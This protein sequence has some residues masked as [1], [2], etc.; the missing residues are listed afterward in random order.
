M[1]KYE[2]NIKVEQIKKMVNKGD[3]ETAMKIA[4]TIDWRRVRNANLL[5]MIAQVYEK[6]SEFQEAKEILLLAFERAPVSKRLLFKLTELALKTEDIREAEDYYREFC[7]IAADD[8]RQHL[9]RYMI[10]KVKKA[11]AD[12]LVNTLERYTSTELDEKWM[13][14]LAE[15]YRAAGREEDCVRTC[16]RIMLMF[17]IGKYVDKA[18]ELKLRYAPLTNYQM[19]LVEN[20]DKY[21]AKL[22][23][24][25]QKYG[26]SSDDSEM[27]A[28]EQAAADQS[29]DEE[30][31]LASERLLAEREASERAAQQAAREMAV[32][33]FSDE[34]PSYSEPVYSEPV[35]S[36]Q[37]IPDPAISDPTDEEL[38]ASIHQAEIEDALA[39]ELSRI[40]VEDYKQPERP[41]ERTKVLNDIRSVLPGAEHAVTT[42][43]PRFSDESRSSD[44]SRF[45]E[46]PVYSS[47]PQ[48]QPSETWP[49][50][51]ETAAQEPA[52]QAEAH[53]PTVQEPMMQEPEE[54][55]MPIRNH[56]MIEARTP[57]KGLEM[58]VES[59]RKIHRETGTKNPVIKITGSKLSRRG[60]A[61][62]ADK[63]MGKDLIIE[64]AG[65]LSETDLNELC[66]LIK[67]DE[68]GMIVVLVDNPKQMEDLHRFNPELAQLF[69]CIGV[70]SNA[71]LATSSTVS[72]TPVTPAPAA[73]TSAS[74]ASVSPS[75]ASSAASSAA[76]LEP[77]ATAVFPASSEKP[78]APSQGMKAQKAAR[79]MSPD[80]EMDLDEFA[81][82]A[83]R[84]AEEIDCSI[85]GKSMLALYERIEIMEEDGIPLTR[86]NAEELI[87]EAADRAEKP[88]LGRRITGIFS[89]KYDK[90]GLL[91]LRE[92]HFI[93]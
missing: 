18:M 8:P 84:Y 52:Y 36:G 90:N 72:S 79:Q 45:S 82:Y 14:E 5:S 92:E 20:R 75:P 56:L 46:H 4:D 29:E 83:C 49:A 44:D 69:E 78:A 86:A 70:Q 35:Y 87:E 2:F 48:M 91:I 40:S 25:E 41:L 28:D 66:E 59:L 88:S 17:G 7:E 26:S 34:E 11:P 37:A 63:L 61:K 57:E 89:S 33:E 64:E 54:E 93:G 21:E 77:A 81:E 71:S 32:T 73:P 53:Q 10:L 13:Y 15:L 24:V 30:Y 23:A 80:E 31:E 85:S 68:S 58:A 62:S 38:E 65:D 16:D 3:Y 47:A 27:Y 42:E 43:N 12:Q 6:N 76:A 22:R 60:I 55:L 74:S 51:Q 19:D 39:E 50:G 1:D 67:Y 9:L